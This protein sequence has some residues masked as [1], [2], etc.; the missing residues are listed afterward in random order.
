[1]PWLASS[2][3]ATAL[4]PLGRLEPRAIAGRRFG[5]IARGAA[6]PLPQAGKLCG[7]GADLRT[8]LV[9]LLPLRKDQLSDGGRRRQPVRF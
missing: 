2:L 5:G 7:H 6:D 3:A 1:M 8:E 9:N 4:A